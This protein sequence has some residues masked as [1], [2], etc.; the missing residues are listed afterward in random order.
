MPIESAR[1]EYS[2]GTTVMK[3]FISKQKKA[4]F[5]YPGVLVFPEWWGLTDY[6]EL[7]TKQLAELGY[8]AMA[9]DMYGE[10]KI[11]SD[12]AEAGSLMNGILSKLEEGET[13]VLAAMDF[14]KSHSEVDANRL[15]AIGYCF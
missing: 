6:L 8:V 5:A 12:P 15:G 4:E 9:V 10:G 14:L 1:V 3:S 13:R 2:A 11:A 7:R